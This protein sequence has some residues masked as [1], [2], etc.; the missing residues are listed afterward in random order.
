MSRIISGKLRLNVQPVYPVTVI[1][2][3]IE[4]VRPASTARDVRIHAMLEPEAGPVLGD[5][6]R[7]QQVVWNLLSNAI[8][9]TPKGGNIKVVLRRSESHVRMEMTDT[10]QGMKPE[11]IPHIFERFRQA[12][13]SS[14]RTHGGLGLGLAIVKQLVELHG[15]TVTAASLGE[16]KGSQFTVLL[17]VIMANARFEPDALIPRQPVKKPPTA[18]DRCRELQGLSILAV[19][20]EPDARNLLKRLLE[21]CGAQVRIAGSAEEA[22]NILDV[23]SPHVVISDIGMPTLDGY[24]FIRL[25]R[26]LPITKDTPAIALTAFARS[27]DRTLRAACRISRP[28]F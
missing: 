15:G 8:K 9:F 16:G 11:L 19:D 20:D 10:G 1:E 27:E 26:K 13:S 21:E 22:L 17:P 18:Q 28:S 14:T 12:D 4:T 23:Y 7:L 25:F 6:N 3:A 2:A 24:E 5:P